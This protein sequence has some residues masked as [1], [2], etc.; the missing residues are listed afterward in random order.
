MVGVGV[1]VTEE[2]IEDEEE[3]GVLD[4][5][6]VLENTGVFVEGIED[7]GVLV[8]TSC[9]LDEG[10]IEGMNEEVGAAEEDK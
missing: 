3:T 9:E 10:V 1:G 4:T 6:G 8:E 2:A 7:R 5:K